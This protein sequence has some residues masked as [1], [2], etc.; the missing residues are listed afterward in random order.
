MP[1]DPSGKYRLV[2]IFQARLPGGVPP[3]VEMVNGGREQQA[4]LNC[5]NKIVPL[6]VC[7]K[8]LL[9]TR[10]FVQKRKALPTLVCIWKRN[11]YHL[12]NSLNLKFQ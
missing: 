8:R 1:S 12:N 5:L 3:T 9:S 6:S 10:L 2:Y 4:I 11:P 7:K